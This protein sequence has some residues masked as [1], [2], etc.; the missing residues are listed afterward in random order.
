M[1]DRMKNIMITPKTEW[2]AIAAETTAPKQVIL[3]YV[4]PLVAIAALAGFVSGSLIG[5][6][7]LLG[8]TFRMPILWGLVLFVYQLLAG[9]LGVFI[10]AFIVDALAPTFGGHKDF[11]QAMK[12]V[13]YSYT[14][15]TVGAVLGILPWLGVL[16]AL[17]FGLYCIYLLYLGLPKLMKNPPEKSVAYTVVTIVVA[18][19]VFVIIGFV[20]TLIMAPAMIGAARM[21]AA[22]PSMTYERPKSGDPK[23]QAEAALGALGV[24][25]SGGKGVE[26]VQLDA[27]KPMLPATFAGLPQA[28]T[29]SERSGVTGLMVAKAGATYRDASKRVDLQV[30]D[31]GGAAGLVGLA[32][33]MGVQ[34]ERE[35]D[36]RREVTRK[37]GNRMVHEE[38]SKTGGNNKYAVVLA[39]RFVV[40]ADG[41]GVDIDTLKSAVGSLDLARLEAMK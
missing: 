7:S 21:G 20:S 4:L 35:N 30:V 1:I 37:E 38:V 19:V 39:N 9:V 14:S 28:S 15:A 10:L 12:L 32:S 13:A 22:S 36:K 11:N 31:T 41:K 27:L 26:P 17:V 8:G 25:M 6:S 34:G 24:A 2:D 23:K 5:T 29:K 40:S 33:W 18:I 16:F 3:G